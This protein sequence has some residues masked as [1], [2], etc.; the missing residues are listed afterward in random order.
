MA[1]LMDTFRKMKKN[2]PENVALLFST[3]PMSDERY[4]T[5]VAK[6]ASD[7]AS[8]GRRDPHRDR[9]MDHTARLRAIRGAVE[10]MQKGQTA[11]LRK[12][13][14]QADGH[15]ASA[16][17]QAPDDYAG[18]LMMA[19]CRLAQNRVG[20]ALRYAEQARAVYPEEPQADHVIGVA[21]TR[22][23]RFDSAL[24]DFRRY[25]RRL[26]GNANT[27]FFQGLCFEGMGRRQQA[28]R[29]YARYGQM[30]PSGEFRR[31]AQTRLVEWGYAGP[32]A[33]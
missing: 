1:E 29:E 3:H 17:K 26:P 20:E 4:N 6:I 15:F 28:A 7:Y 22:V 10:E 21:K 2:R 13:Y 5:A 18:L 8:V 12:N 30:A 27:V 9:Y 19:K 32:A 31:H 23:R 14:G 24:A 11:M 16:L 33:K 25:E